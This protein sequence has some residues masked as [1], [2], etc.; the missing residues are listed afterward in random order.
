MAMTCSSQG[1]ALAFMALW[2]AVRCTHGSRHCDLPSYSNYP[3]LTLTN[4]RGTSFSSAAAPKGHVW[5][6]DYSCH[7]PMPPST[8]ERSPWPDPS[9]PMFESWLPCGKLSQTQVC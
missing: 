6:A 2:S 8:A 9:A 1:I 4:Q 5:V 7:P 3:S